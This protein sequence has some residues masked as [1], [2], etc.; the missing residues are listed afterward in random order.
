MWI[1]AAFAGFAVILILPKDAVPAETA[2]AKVIIA[3]SAT[4]RG[5]F[6]TY[7]ATGV[8]GVDAGVFYRRLKSGISD[9]CIR[10]WRVVIVRDASGARTHEERER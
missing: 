4:R 8:N 9:T 3:I 6:V 5:H 1:E 10:G 2:R 7:I